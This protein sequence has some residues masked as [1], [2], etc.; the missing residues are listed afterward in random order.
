MDIKE[1]LDKIIFSFVP[2]ENGEISLVD[3]K[4]LASD[5]G[6]TSIKI[7]QLFMAIESEF[8]INL[9][10]SLFGEVKSYQYKHL[11]NTLKQYLEVDV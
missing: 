9:N 7:I 11:L 5:L 10:N 4:N 6:F 2:S 3:E 1:R 8:K